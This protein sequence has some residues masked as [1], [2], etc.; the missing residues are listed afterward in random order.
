MI[1]ENLRIDFIYGL[2]QFNDQ[3]SETQSL[4][5]PVFKFSNMCAWNEDR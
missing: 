5:R 1:Y 4:R 3:N 2:M